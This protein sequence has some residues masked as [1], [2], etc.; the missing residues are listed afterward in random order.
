[1]VWCEF[2]AYYFYVKMKMSA[3]F[4]ICIRAALRI[5]RLKEKKKETLAQFLSREF[6]ETYQNT[7]FKEWLQ[8]PA[9]EVTIHNNL[10]KYRK[11]SRKISVA[12][13]RCSVTTVFAFRTNFTD[14]SETYD[15]M[16]LYYNYVTLWFYTSCILIQ[17]PKRLTHLIS[18][19][20]FSAPWKHQKTLWFF[21]G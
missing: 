3:D 19:Y 14:H 18:M 5:K 4:H 2:S 15:F 6:C 9:S 7:Y 10:S 13:L 16:K 11:L 1:M 21:R 20:P 12:V 8:R 17:Q